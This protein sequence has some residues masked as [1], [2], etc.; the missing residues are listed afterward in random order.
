[1]AWDGKW[2]LRAFHDALLCNGSLPL[3]TLAR[4]IATWLDGKDGAATD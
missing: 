1:M 2:Y 4:S 3:P